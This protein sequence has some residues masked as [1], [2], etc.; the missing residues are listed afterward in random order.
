MIGVVLVHALK[1]DQ[2]KDLVSVDDFYHPALRAIYQAIC[3]CDADG[4]PIDLISVAEQMRTLGTIDKLNTCGG[5]DYLTDL[6]ARMVTSENVSYHAQV[7]R[8]KGTA[9]RLV[10]SAR[11]IA[12][13]GYSNESNLSDLVTLAETALQ[14]AR[15]EVSS[16]RPQLIELGTAIT[17]DSIA[18]KR[19]PVTTGIRCI[20]EQLGGGLFP[21]ELVMLQAGPGAGKTT[22]ATLMQG[23]SVASDPSACGLY[24]T[25]EMQPEELQARRACQI[26]NDKGIKCSWR[27][28]MRGVVPL[29]RTREATANSRV[30]VLPIAFDPDPVSTV[31]AYAKQL[32]ARFGRPPFL[33][34]D[35]LQAFAVGSTDDD[36]RLVTAARAYEF[37]QLAIEL[38][39]PI[40]VISSINRA[41]YGSKERRDSDEPLDFLSAGKEAGEIEYAAAVLLH[42]DVK[43]EADNH[44]WRSARLVVSKARFGLLGII[45]LTFH[46]ASGRFEPSAASALSE[47]DRRVLEVISTKSIS[48]A[49]QVAESLKKHRQQ[50]LQS[51]AKLRGLSLIK[52]APNGVF[53]ATVPGTTQEVDENE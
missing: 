44:G 43:A 7:V 22:L 9:R 20:D 5:V 46:G 29:D 4:Q 1:F 41:A 31:R 39:V 19:A 33:V 3:S 48:S 26:L 24:V 11:E 47:L 30:F 23:R 35:Y 21:G 49:N 16:K 13:R 18:L 10:E 2:V 50:V 27:D 34:I 36:R 32:E 38:R 17:A 51:V 37:Q 15:D 6:M 12:A 40:L 14:R 42:L 52:K 25:T 8:D 53:L 28:V 45:G